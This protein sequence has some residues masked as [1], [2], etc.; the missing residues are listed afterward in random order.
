M[1]SYVFF[2]SPGIRAGDAALASSRYEAE[3]DRYEGLTPDRVRSVADELSRAHGLTV[4]PSANDPEEGL[5]LEEARD[6]VGVD[7]H[8]DRFGVTVQIYGGDSE[9]ESAD[10]LKRGSAIARTASRL[11]EGAVYDAERGQIVD[12]SF[13]DADLARA[14]SAALAR[15]EDV[16]GSQKQ[17]LVAVV[18]FMLIPTVGFGLVRLYVRGFAGFLIMFGMMALGGAFLSRWSRRPARPPAVPAGPGPR[19]F[20]RAAPGAKP[21]KPS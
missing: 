14:A 8:V 13:E 18:L 21:I 4:D 7:V 15:R 20:Q 5:D 6:V 19:D 9:R 17:K 11:L 16:G 1:G 12:L 3:D 2:V 10:N